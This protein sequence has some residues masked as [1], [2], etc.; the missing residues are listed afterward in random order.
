MNH[1]DMSCTPYLSDTE[2]VVTQRS[3]VNSYCTDSPLSRSSLTH[4]FPSCTVCLSAQDLSISALHDIPK[5]QNDAGKSV[6]RCL[7]SNR[8]VTLNGRRVS[9]RQQVRLPLSMLWM[10]DRAADACEA[11]WLSND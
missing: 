9:L 1:N 11:P 3:S 6:L 8:S 4:L 5:E 7:V 10:S 2:V